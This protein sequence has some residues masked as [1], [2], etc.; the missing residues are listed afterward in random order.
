M[1]GE[2]S[3]NAYTWVCLKDEFEKA[4]PL[5]DFLPDRI[6]PGMVRAI[7]Y[8]LLRPGCSI[9][10]FGSNYRPEDALARDVKKVISDF[11]AKAFRIALTWLV[12]TS[13]IF[14]KPKTDER[15]FG[16][17]SHK[18]KDNPEAMK[19]YEIVQNTN[20]RFSS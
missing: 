3:K 2:R 6:N 9:N 14:T 20:K 15:V 1:D 5:P 8:V 13:V 7:F 11:C 10:L 16:I 18:P 4:F 17:S 19:L 12:K